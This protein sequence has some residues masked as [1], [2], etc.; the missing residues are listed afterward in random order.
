MKKTLSILLAAALTA[1]LLA[2]PVSAEGEHVHQW[3]KEWSYDTVAHWHECTAPDCPITD[4][5]QKDGYGEHTGE[6]LVQREGSERS[7]GLRVQTCPACNHF[8]YDLTPAALPTADSYTLD[9]RK[10]PVTLTG[11][12]KDALMTTLGN[13]PRAWLEV[14]NLQ[15]PPDGYYVDLNGDGLPDLE[16]RYTYGPSLPDQRPF[17]VISVTCTATEPVPLDSY[18]KALS[19]E[20]L[21]GALK[22]GK[23]VFGRLTVLFPDNLD[24]LSDLRGH[25]AQD[26]VGKAIGQRWVNGYP[27]GTFRPEGTVTRAELTKMLLA[28]SRSLPE[29]YYVDQMAYYASPKPAGFADMDGHWLTAKGWTNAALVSGILHPSDYEGKAFE[30]DRPITRGEI[31]V[32]AVRSLGLGLAAQQ[33]GEESLTFTDRET[34]S[35]DQAG[36]IREAARTGII[37]GYPDGSFGHDRTATRAEAVTMV[38]RVL[39]QM[40]RGSLRTLPEEEDVTIILRGSGDDHL[41]GYDGREGCQVLD[42][43]VYVSLLY[44]ADRFQFM[45][46]IKPTAAPQWRWDPADQSWTQPLEDG[47]SITYRAGDRTCYDGEKKP[48]EALALPA[49]VHMAY[50]RPMIPVFDLN[51]GAACGPWACSWDG[52]ARRLTIYTPWAGDTGH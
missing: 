50:G 44:A 24:R 46:Y 49:P 23:D 28:A 11:A 3:S 45:S 33:P 21:A 38:F 14:F 43:V 47:S 34:F 5:T 4:N 27:D 1:G 37:T 32:L 16:A 51:T 39:E 15:G 8:I 10:G 31:A 18:D 41:T 22:N 29:T 42:G 12:E 25:W 17:P 19:A 36:Y 9:L 26:A 13:L 35:P 48:V 7:S 52:S 2:V 30:P 6:W 20:K 40:D